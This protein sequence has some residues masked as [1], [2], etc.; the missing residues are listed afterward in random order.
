MPSE[1][2]TPIPVVLLKG[3]VRCNK[4]RIFTTKL[5]IDR[6]DESQMRL[7]LK[8]ERHLDKTYLATFI[9]H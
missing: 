7:K 4:V 1:Q 9:L 3:V 2:L 5:G 6:L 8:S